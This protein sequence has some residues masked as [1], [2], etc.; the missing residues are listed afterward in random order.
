MSVTQSAVSDET[1]WAAVPPEG[2]IRRYIHYAS[3]QTDAATA[4]QVGV[5]LT[6]LAALIPR[7]ISL[8]RTG[9]SQQLNLYTILIGDSVLSRKTTS[10]DLGLSVA[11][12]VLQ[13]T[14][15][16]APDS[17]QG[18]L[19]A[20]KEA[21]RPQVLVVEPE[22]SRFLSQSGDRGY[23]N[24]LKLGY[25]EI[26]D[27]G[28]VGR[29]TKDTAIRIEGACVSMLAGVAG[30]HIED[31]MTLTDF[32]GGFW[33]RFLVIQGE[34]ERYEP[35]PE[36][37]LDQLHWLRKYA[38][39][40]ANGVPGEW[41]TTIRVSPEA[42]VRL[43]EWG[44]KT[45]LH[46][47][48]L[49]ATDYRRGIFGRSQLIVYKCAALIAFDRYMWTYYTASEA[50]RRKLVAQPITISADD[51][52][53]AERIAQIHMASAI[54]ISTSIASTT[55]MRA[56]RRVLDV[57]LAAEGAVSEGYLA[58][59]AQLLIREL[60]PIVETLEAQGL[61]TRAA[62]PDL[63]PRYI[64]T[65]TPETLANNRRTAEAPPAILANLPVPL[66]AVYADGARMNES[67]DGQVVFHE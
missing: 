48:S 7:E 11:T 36:P 66:D 45:T 12:D 5:A 26:Y 30:V 9:K 28:S 67:A 54:K 1:A 46:A 4:F 56:R 16:P 13:D 64:A 34:P 47:R 61:I 18:L 60:R 21:P 38:D 40:L 8:Y 62:S 37:R 20:I 6:I 42:K 53:Y 52:V 63:S 23:L 10:I 55:S 50:A 49:P 19:T 27:G 33:A 51:I 22:F 43:S 44:E 39:F 25:T 3:T 2:F 14:I 35:H 57:A 15:I 41:L 65:A 32:T 29:R 59:K 58:E 24:G 31:H 17:W